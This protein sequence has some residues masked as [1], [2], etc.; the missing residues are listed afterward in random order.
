MYF[1]TNST[2]FIPQWCHYL[3]GTSEGKHSIHF[4]SHLI[5]LDLLQLNFQWANTCLS[6]L[7]GASKNQDKYSV[8]QNKLNIR[9]EKILFFNFHVFLIAHSVVYNC[10]AT[11]TTYYLAILF[12]H[13]NI[14]STLKW[15]AFYNVKSDFNKTVLSIF[16]SLTHWLLC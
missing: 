4:T 5:H 3:E 15:L 14:S 7:L 16:F 6:I 2:R 8:F 9:H 12:C 11:T 10:A 13:I 1:Q